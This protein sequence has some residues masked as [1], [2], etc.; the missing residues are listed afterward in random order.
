MISIF[1]DE[2]QLFLIMPYS[3]WYNSHN[4]MAYMLKNSTNVS[5]YINGIPDNASNSFSKLK[6]LFERAEATD[7]KP[8]ESVTFFL[9]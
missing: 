9:F 8:N 5:V 7:L 1:N 4:A 2:P 3:P 6:S